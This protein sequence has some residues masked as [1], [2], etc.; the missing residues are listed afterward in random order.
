MMLDGPAEENDEQTQLD[1]V[2]LTTLL[3]LVK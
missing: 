2:A 3:S 1:K